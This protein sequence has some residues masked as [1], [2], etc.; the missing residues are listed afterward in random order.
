MEHYHVKVVI[1]TKLEFI[2]RIILGNFIAKAFRTLDDPQDKEKVS[3]S[4]DVD[5]TGLCALFLLQADGL[6]TVDVE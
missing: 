3:F 4:G 2:A 6:L 5:N 1:S